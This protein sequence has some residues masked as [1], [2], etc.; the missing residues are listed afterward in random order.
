MLATR[1]RW[2]ALC[3]R[4]GAKDNSMAGRTVDSTYDEIVEAY[5]ETGR[6]YHVLNHI[7]DGLKSLDEVRFFLKLLKYLDSIEAGW[8]FHDFVYKPGNPR[9][10]E[11]SA[12]RAEKVLWELNV[13]QPLR[14]RTTNGIRATRHNY[15]PWD[16]S[17]QIMADIDLV[18]LALPPKLFDENT[19]K[20]REEYRQI[21][22]N[23]KDFQIGRAQFFLKFIESRPS[24]YLTKYFRD[25]YEAQA[26]ENI[27]RLIAEAD[28]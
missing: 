20:N 12:N 26:Q 21:V 6:Y 27:R 23:D 16:F 28:I 8:W 11:E 19:A 17:D 7:S 1:E 10:E 25:K 18:S 24:V 2:R 9:N 3:Q 13:K 5:A 22:P 15:I 14:I 4:I